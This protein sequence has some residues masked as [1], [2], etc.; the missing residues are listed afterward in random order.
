MA[1]EMTT[2]ASSK[3]AC[4]TKTTNDPSYMAAVKQL[5]SLQMVK[6]WQALLVG[7]E[8]RMA[9]GWSDE[10]EFVSGHCHWSISFYENGSSVMQLWNSF[11]VG[12][13]AGEIYIMDYVDGD[14]VP[15]APS[16]TLL[17]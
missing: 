15:L 5:T 6:D 1:G 3:Q 7:S 17:K 16:S 8:S 12:L 11:Q 9:L 2:R 10:T 14:Y 13:T 4:L